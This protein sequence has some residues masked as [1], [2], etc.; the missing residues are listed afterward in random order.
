MGVGE[1]VSSEE[2]I[3]I[4][5]KTNNN[6][7]QKTKNNKKTTKNKK[8]KTKKNNKSKCKKKQTLGQF[9]WKDIAPTSTKATN[10]KK[11][12][13]KVKIKKK[14]N[15]K[16]LESILFFNSGS[17]GASFPYKE[18]EEI[19]GTITLNIKNPPTATSSFPNSCLITLF[20]K[21]KNNNN[22]NKMLI[23][24]RII[25]IK[26]FKKKR[27]CDIS[28]CEWNNCFVGCVCV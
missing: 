16:K 21:K 2:K 14:I 7:K 4:K 20:L 15:K 12:K 28:S 18:G 9:Y 6:K 10:L 19:Q 8:Q 1:G 17:M 27:F 25:I 5:Q 3:R 22:N 26:C 13:K 23:R 24:K 11:E